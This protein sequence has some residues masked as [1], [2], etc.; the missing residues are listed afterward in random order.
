[1]TIR[2]KTKKKD[3]NKG[4]GGEAINERE[5]VVIHTTHIPTVNTSINKC[6]E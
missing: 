4:E 6:T 2:G 5:F 1:M 3:G